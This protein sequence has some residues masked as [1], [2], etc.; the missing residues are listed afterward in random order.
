MAAADANAQP[1]VNPDD[2]AAPTNNN[3]MLVRAGII[4][5]ILIVAATIITFLVSQV[6]TPDMAL[7]FGDLDLAESNKIVT[8]I[9]AMGIKTKVQAGGTQV[10]VPANQVARL[11]MALAEQGLP[12]G[13][14]I[15]YEI[16]DRGDTLGTTSFVQNINKVRALEGELSRTISSL[17][18]ISS[19]RVHL[20]LPKRELFSRQQQEP[21]A[22]VV[23]RYSGSGK[24]K[25]SQVTAIQQLIAAAVPGLSMSNIAVVDDKG[26]LLARGD[27][28]ERGVNPLDTD[29]SRLEY[30]DRMARNIEMLIGR[31]VGP[32]K[33][34]AE[35]VIDMDMD[36]VTENSEIYDPTKLGHVPLSVQ[37]VEEGA[38]SNESTTAGGATVANNIPGAG[39]DGGAGGNNSKSSRTE[40]TINYHA[41]KMLRTHIHEAGGIK[42]ISAAI[43]VDGMYETQEDGT[44]QYKER[45]QQE[46]EKLEKLVKSAMGFDEGRGDQIEIINMRF[47]PL[48]TNI[49]TIDDGRIMGLER[50]QFVKIIEMLIICLFG[51]L[52][53]HFVAKPTFNIL[54]DRNR[55]RHYISQTGPDG[56]TILVSQDSRQD[57]QA[58]GVNAEKQ[59]EDEKDKGA[60]GKENEDGDNPKELSEIESLVQNKKIEGELR[61]S[62]IDTINKVIDDY[63]S[64]TVAQIRHWMRER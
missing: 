48:D 17:N 25:R 44:S 55:E 26:V 52:V 24:L 59:K 57:P 54:I 1:G 42:K 15:G 27:G 18:Q 34:R 20:V 64:Q 10:L 60:E 29:D 40:E 9:E 62:T 63:P 32:D 16:F 23:I 6:T 21:R 31:I 30:E 12:V 5:T 19:A 28:K 39:A 14:S 43:L 7:L 51:F 22:S 36:K 2:L 56:Q 37:T 4:G 53:M 11:R 61:L 13:G 45:S 33:V 38:D 3:N 47:A 49:G 8:K 50:H 41:G 35:I 46:I 58:I